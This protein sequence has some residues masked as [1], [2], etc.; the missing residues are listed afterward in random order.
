MKGDTWAK[1]WPCTC[2]GEDRIPLI[3]CKANS[4]TGSHPWWSW[5]NS[6]TIF[7]W[8]QY[9]YTFEGENCGNRKLD[10]F[11]LDER[12]SDERIPCRDPRNRDDRF[13][14]RPRDFWSCSD[15]DR[16][17]KLWQLPPEHQ[18]NC[19]AQCQNLPTSFHHT[20][21]KLVHQWP[22]LQYK[23]LWICARGTQ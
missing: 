7:L 1:R 11:L 23:T 15:A 14:Y 22:R 5:S 21:H 2:P 3:P 20:R 13:Y 17:E 4:A 10:K 19:P 12:G 6:Q 18:K 8:V 16:R 9:P